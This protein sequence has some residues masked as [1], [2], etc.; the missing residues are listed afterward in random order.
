MIST[1]WG[2]PNKF[3]AGF[4]PEDVAKGNYGTHINVFDWKKG[5]LIQVNRRVTCLYLA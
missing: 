1:E 4:K 5:K 2:H 3:A